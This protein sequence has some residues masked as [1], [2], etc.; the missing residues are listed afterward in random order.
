M[1]SYTFLPKSSRCI[2]ATRNQ[3]IHQMF[4][5][6]QGSFIFPENG[7]GISW[8]PLNSMFLNSTTPTSEEGKFES[9]GEKEHLII[10]RKE[11][12]VFAPSWPPPCLH[13]WLFT[14]SIYFIDTY[15]ALYIF[16]SKADILFI[17]FR[18]GFLLDADELEGV[19]ELL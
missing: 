18:D 9:K 14:D 17:A 1:L 19:L 13:H 10:Q 11:E 8:P 6:I 16:A 3:F 12:G 7:N 15:L 5:L 4:K 2:S